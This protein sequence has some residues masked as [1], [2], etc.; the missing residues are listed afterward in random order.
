[1]KL[2]LVINSTILLISASTIQGFSL[3]SSSSKTF[4]RDTIITYSTNV[5]EGKEIENDFTPVNNMILLKKGDIVDQTQGGI[6]L[7][8]KV[9]L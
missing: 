1:M 3:L 7:T 4:R 5:L 2:P 6:F 8:G 9:C